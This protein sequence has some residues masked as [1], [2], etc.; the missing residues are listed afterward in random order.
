MLASISA[1]PIAD[2]KEGESVVFPLRSLGRVLGVEVHFGYYT[3]PRDLHEICGGCECDRQ[4]R[5]PDRLNPQN[6]KKGGEHGC[7][8]WT[9]SQR[10]VVQRNKRQKA[11]RSL[12]RGGCNTKARKDIARLGMGTWGVCTQLHE[13]R[14]IARDCT[15]LRLWPSRAALP[16]RRPPRPPQGPQLRRPGFSRS[17]PSG[18]PLR[19]TPT[20]TRPYRG[21]GARGHLGRRPSSRR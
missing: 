4:C 5:T 11:L 14:E 21:R 18:S 2:T 12:K 1:L 19:S 6:T 15:R 8:R 13:V 16:R 20:S 10:K 7:D 3:T 17:R 9:F